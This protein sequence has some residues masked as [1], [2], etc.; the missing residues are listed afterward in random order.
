MASEFKS[1]TEARGMS[2]LRLVLI[3]GVPSPWSQAVRGIFRVKGIGYV[4][5]ELAEGEPRDLLREWTGQDAFPAVMYEDE[6]P[7][8][9]WEEI[10]W[11]AERLAPKPSLLPADPAERAIMFGLSREICGEMGLSWCQRLI[12]LGAPMRSGANP[13]L[14]AMNV[15]F[16]SS[17]EEMAQAQRRVLEVLGLLSDRLAE[18]AK[19]GHRYFMGPD[20][21]ALDLYWATHCN[22]L[23][24]LPAEQMPLAPPVAEMFTAS[25]PETQAALAPEL[26]A[27]RDFVYETHLELPVEL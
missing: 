6:R 22:L 19:A 7:R 18:S 21:T 17:D 23:S 25:D 27:H 20:L 24:P 4:K 16:G 26:L 5:V 12:S 8:T 14:A 10:L 11:F 13:M 2:G 3:R 9:S 15:K 1:I